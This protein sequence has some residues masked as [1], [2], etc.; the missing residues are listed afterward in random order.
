VINYTIYSNT[1]STQWV[2]FVH[3]AGGSSAIWFKQIREFQKEYN[4]TLSMESQMTTDLTSATG[5][6]PL[7]TY[8]IHLGIGPNYINANAYRERI[9]PHFIAFQT[10]WINGANVYNRFS[11]GSSDNPPI[12]VKSLYNVGKIEFEIFCPTIAGQTPIS[13]TAS[14]QAIL[15][16]EEV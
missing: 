9:T 12:R 11:V 13:S 3:G 4:V 2:T 1:K 5:I 14:Y 7:E 6:N 8:C 16:F 10:Q 15:R